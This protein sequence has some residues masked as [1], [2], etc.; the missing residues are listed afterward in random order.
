MAIRTITIAV[1]ARIVLTVPI[2]LTILINDFIILNRTLNFLNPKP[3][4]SAASQQ[5]LGNF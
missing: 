4:S 5:D 2:V 3:K 1:T